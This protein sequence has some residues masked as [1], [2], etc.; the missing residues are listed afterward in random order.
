MRLPAIGVDELRDILS[1]AWR[2]HAP[3]RLV[4]EFD[5]VQRP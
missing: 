1:D 4:A 5:A 2:L 3:R